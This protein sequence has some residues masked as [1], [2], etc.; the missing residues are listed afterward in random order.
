MSN[1]KAAVS[2]SEVT[3]LLRELVAIDS[4]NRDVQPGAAGESGVADFVRRFL[5]GIGLEVT[6]VEV[7]PGRPNVSGLL[8]VPGATRTL[9]LDSHMDTMPA[10]GMG[11]R[12]H[13]PEI[14]GGRMYGRGSCDDKASLASMLA[15]MKAL[16]GISDSLPVNVLML[17]SMGEENTM[18]GIKHFAQSGVHVDAAIVGE[19]TDL[20]IVIAHKGYLRL[21]IRT[22]GRA[23]HTSD[24]S[25]GDSAIYQ[26]ADVIALIRD[27]LQYRW[28][29]VSHPLLPPPTLAIGK[30]SGGQAVNI[31][32]AECTIDVDR[33][34]LPHEDPEAIVAEVRG[35]LAD[36]TKR[37]PELKIELD[38]PTAIDRGLDTP[39][40]APVVLAARA[41]CESVLGKAEVVGVSYG[42]HAAPLWR[43][44]DIPSIVL[45]PGSIA[46][47]HTADEYVELAQLP[48][49]VEIY[50]RAALRGLGLA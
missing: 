42:T 17:A 22:V 44:A 50:C 31:V 36:L 24:P 39:A 32:P 16:E 26:M 7:E 35:A 10:G 43:I 48:L 12:A 8:R 9:L 46:Q 37:R 33:R 4:T 14:R 20:R 40:T 23:A 3:D 1:L 41:A 27:D 38:Q 30:I 2:T 49:A 29:S 47:A 21:R 5:D 18:A 13:R 15:A 28:R 25:A 45:G 34:L 19:P 6:V 11:D